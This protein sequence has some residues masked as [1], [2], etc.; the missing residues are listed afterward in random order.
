MEK[1]TINSAW[2]RSNR[3]HFDDIV[4]DY[5]KIRPE[6]PASLYEDIF[7]YIS[8]ENNDKNALEIGAGTGKATIPFL[9]AGFFV[10]ASEIGA[11]MTAFLAEK[12]KSRENFNAINDAFEDVQLD[13]NSYDIIYAA[14]AFH[15]VDAEIGCP[16]A[17]RLLKKGGVFALFRYNFMPTDNEPLFNEIQSF[18]EKYYYKPYIKPM[19][20]SKENFDTPE[21]IYRGFRFENMA[22][23]GFSDI[24]MKFYDATKTYTADEYIDFL[25]TLSDH[26]CLPPHDKEALFA[27]IK[28]V[29]I[30]H[31]GFYKMDIIFQLYMGKKE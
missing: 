18:Y 4:V 27:G 24:C 16:K 20:M 29:I 14:S 6:Y 13:E 1:S 9:D 23:Y 26:I 2:E 10:T 3:T 31:G 28:E 12:F 15:W 5:D 30:K 19:V 21:E 7:S 17:F 22:N 8:S 11:N 25:D